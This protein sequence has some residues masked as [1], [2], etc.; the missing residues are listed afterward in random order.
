MSKPKQCPNIL[1]IIMDAARADHL[2]CYGYALQ[3]TPHLDRQ[4]QSGVRF[5]LDE[6]LEQHLR[7]LGH[8]D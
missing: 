1:L 3:T 7:D 2:S 4:A 6:Y 5:T 8:I